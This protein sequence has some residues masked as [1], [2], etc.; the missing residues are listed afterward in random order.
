MSI[1]PLILFESPVIKLAIKTGGLI[2]A[3]IPGSTQH[4]S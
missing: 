4:T 1:K 2:V 3:E